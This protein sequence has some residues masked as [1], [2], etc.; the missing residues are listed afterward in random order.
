[1]SHLCS[2][3][4][5]AVMLDNDATC[6]ELAKGSQDVPFANA[7]VPELA[8]HLGSSL[9]LFPDLGDEKDKASIDAETK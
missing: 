3:P 6:V 4:I 7:D 8:C 1:L 2:E 5:N 9:L